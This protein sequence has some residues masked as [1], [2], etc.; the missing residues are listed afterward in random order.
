MTMRAMLLLLFFAANAVG[1]NAVRVDFTLHTAGPDGVPLE[2]QR[3]YYL[4]RPA[5]LPRANPVPMVLVMEAAPNGGPAGFFQHRADLGGFLVVSC[6]FSGNSTGTPGTQWNAGNPAITGYEDIDYV[7][8]VINRVRASDNANDAF[9]AGLSK[10]GHISLAYACVRPSM[11]RAASSVDEFMGLTTNIP[12]APVPV[13]MFHGTLDTNVP[14]TMSKD[15][16]DAWRARNN[17]VNA[18]AVTTYESS[19]LIP[20]MVSQATWRDPST[21]LQAAFVTIIGGAHAYPTPNAQTGYD[22]TAGMWTFFSQF[23][24]TPQ[25]TPKILS[26][27]VDNVQ[28]SGQPASF[29]VTAAGKPPLAYRWQR[30]GIDIPGA[31]ANWYTTPAT[32]PA[33]DGAKFQAVVTNA[34]GSV[35]SAAAIL[36]VKAAPAGPAITTSPADQS[37]IAGRPAAFTVVAAGMP[38][39]RYQ[40]KKNGMDIAGA[41]SPSL[42]IPA[43]ITADSGAAFTVTVTG[44]DGSVTSARA[45]LTVTRSPGAPVILTSPARVRALTNQHASF[46][47]VA[48]SPSPMT[49]QWQKGTFNANMIDIPG[50]NAATYTTPLT[51]LADHRTLV[52][53]IVSN[54]AGSVTSASELLLVTAEK[55]LTPAP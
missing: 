4:Y 48:R 41:T 9:I 45:T 10:G 30:N 49:Y 3:H 40:W 24:T 39:L 6:S 26:Q 5:N 47:V 28:F 22:C 43:A 25:T 13:L 35:S 29:W 11:I 14:Y 17:L 21:G 36:T 38:P 44:P 27:P 51:T 18:T 50:A 42:S 34:S 31:T 8:A 2:Q 7:S 1:G 19:P 23:L 52:R 53:C 15:T 37:A 12:S 33:D 54:S 20:G 32:T 46:S 55:K 16:L